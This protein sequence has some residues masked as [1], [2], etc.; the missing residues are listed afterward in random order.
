MRGDRERCIAAGFDD[1][2]AKPFKQQELVAM[3][4]RWTCNAAS[5]VA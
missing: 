5:K 1:Y 2:L 3:I 4:E